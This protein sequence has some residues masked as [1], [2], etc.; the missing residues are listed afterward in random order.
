MK[1]KKQASP[2]VE[3]R[4]LSIRAASAYT[5]ATIWQVRTWA[6]ER[7]VP[8]VQF[9]NRILFDKADLDRYIESQKTKAA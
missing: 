3:P 6:W 4:M 7:R 8:F 9:G 2:L 1:N 5:G